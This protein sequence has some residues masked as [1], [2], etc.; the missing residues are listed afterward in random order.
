MW[1]LT[2]PDIY[3]YDVIMLDEAQDCSEC[4]RDIL[5][6]Q[7][8]HTALV[9]VGDSHQQIYAF[10]K[11]RDALMNVNHTHTYYLTQVRWCID[12]CF[13][14]ASCFDFTMCFSAT[15]FTKA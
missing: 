1:Q 9:F 10:R 8:R 5:E 2:S 6:R 14:I 12:K 7:Q 3:G 15:V 11:A 13:S 4:M